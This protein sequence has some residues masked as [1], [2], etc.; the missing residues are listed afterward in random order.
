MKHLRSALLPLLLYAPAGH[1]QGGLALY[2]A[3]TSGGD[4]LISASSEGGGEVELKAGGLFHLALGYERKLPAGGVRVTYGYKFD[5]LDAENGDAEIT[6][7]PLEAVL[8][9]TFSGRH[10]LGG[11]LVYEMSP[12]YEENIDGLG[13]LDLDFDDATGFMF[14]Y[15]YSTSGSFEWGLR[16]TDIKYEYQDEF[17]SLAFDGASYGLFISSFFD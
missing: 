15:G 9:R 10:N 14:F 17:F 1:A 12:R 3:F 5:S 8:Y 2:G 16:Y 7:Y 11:G 4:T 6:R 13:S